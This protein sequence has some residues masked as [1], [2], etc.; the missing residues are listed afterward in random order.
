MIEMM[1]QRNLIHDFKPTEK[2]A[3]QSYLDKI[4][5][6]DLNILLIHNIF[7]NQEDIQFAENLSKNIYWT[8]CPN[9]NRFIQNINIDYQKFIKHNCKITLGTDSYASNTSL[10]LLDEMKNFNDVEFA[11]VLEWVTING[12][13]ALKIDNNFGSLEIGKK[14]GL[15][16]I[17]HFDFQNRKLKP[18]SKMKRLL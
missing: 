11:K 7:T 3:L 17:E 5:R 15:N 6:D 18:E 9:S 13:R 4:V 10:N 8:L 1:R 2:S 14:P 12:A 16:L